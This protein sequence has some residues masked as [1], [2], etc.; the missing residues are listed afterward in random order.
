[1][2]PH[3]NTAA[4]NMC[5]TTSMPVVSSSCSLNSMAS[6]QQQSNTPAP[7]I[8]QQDSIINEEEY[9]E[10]YESQQ[11]LNSITITN[12]MPRPND[13][14]CALMIITDHHWHRLH[15][16]DQP[17]CMAGMG[18]AIWR[19]IS[20]FLLSFLFADQPSSAFSTIVRKALAI[21]PIQ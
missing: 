9:D 4:S 19:K 5:T 6:T 18:C 13:P 17:F 11:A 14:I 20:P 7:T 3:V 2:Q 21:L 16:A 1:M 8:E 15:S 10:F 12:N